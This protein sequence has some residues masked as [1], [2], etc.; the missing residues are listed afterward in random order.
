MEKKRD[1]Y[2]VKVTRPEGTSALDR[3]RNG[4][5]NNVNMDLKKVG[6]RSV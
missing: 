6:W 5:E 3:Q 2:S 4:W 1:A